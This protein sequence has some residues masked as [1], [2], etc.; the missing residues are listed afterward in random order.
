MKAGTGSIQKIKRKEKD[1]MS[2]PLN[3][4]AKA[5]NM[6]MRNP[7]GII[8]TKNEEEKVLLDK[9][10]MKIMRNNTNIRIENMIMT[11]KNMIAKVIET[12]DDPH[13][14][15]NPGDTKKYIKMKKKVNIIIMMKI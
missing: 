14:A 10:I 15:V 6:Q 1:L 11:Q 7:V 12:E 9:E 2:V 3:M 4:K 13:Q 8:M 5:I